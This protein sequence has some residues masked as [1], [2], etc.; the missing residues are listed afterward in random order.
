MEVQAGRLRSNPMRIGRHEV[1]PLEQI[2]L[3]EVGVSPKAAPTCTTASTFM[4][5]MIVSAAG[6]G[7]V[8][9]R[10]HEHDS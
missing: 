6:R 7:A 8:S 5:T 9:L 10:R 2:V 1:T 4:C 3:V